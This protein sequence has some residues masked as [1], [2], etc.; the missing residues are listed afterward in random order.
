MRLTTLCIERWG[1]YAPCGGN[2][3]AEGESATYADIINN[4]LSSKHFPKC[5]VKE[6]HMACS[7][8]KK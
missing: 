7:R 6:A 1:I 3:L 2:L 4:K 8:Y 5:F